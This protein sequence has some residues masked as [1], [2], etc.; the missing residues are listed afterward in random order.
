MSDEI[1]ST[2]TES[3]IANQITEM[4]K[5]AEAEGE[6]I[7]VRKAAKVLNIKQTEVRDNLPQGASLV[8][9]SNGT[10][11]ESVISLTGGEEQVQAY[12]EDELAASVSS[13]TE[14]VQ[15]MLPKKERRKKM[16]AEPKE[17]VY[18][19]EGNEVIEEKGET[20][21]CAIC[22]NPV[23]RNTIV[24]RGICPLCFRQLARNVGI[25]A[26]KLEEM[27]D[28]EFEV[29]L[30]DENSR[31]RSLE[32]YKE[33]R[34]LTTEQFNEM[35]DR[36]V[37]VKEVFA[38]AKE[39]GYGP[40]RVAQAM[41]GDRFRHEPLGKFG[42]VWTPYFVGARKAWYFH[43]DILQHFDDLKKAEK[44]KVEKKRA[45]GKEGA[46]GRKGARGAAMTPVK[47]GDETQEINSLMAAQSTDDYSADYDDDFENEDDQAEPTWNE[48][49]VEDEQ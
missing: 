43:Q 6:Y 30:G 26:D 45:S 11:S 2:L 47:E 32:E 8:P 17:K 27:S 31:R 16:E 36:L 7:T 33:S 9:G 35:K 24:R 42:S 25:R 18:D 49:P 28:A 34:V 37:P 20:V 12:S 21:I 39:A 40:G 1:L 38:A 44:P 15:K 13:T 19:A 3:P 41:G 5:A 29:I 46:V 22:G 48:G 14:Q 23:R 10:L 4:V